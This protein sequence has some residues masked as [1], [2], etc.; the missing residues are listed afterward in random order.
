MTTCS[1]GCFAKVEPRLGEGAPVFLCDYPPPM[2]ALAKLCDDGVFPV[3]ERF[4]LYACG[5]E[6][7]NG[8]TELRDPAEQRT[9]FVDQITEKK[10]IYGGEYT[11]DE[12]FLA[13][14]PQ[15]PPCAGN[16]LGL[17]RLVMLLLGKESVAEIIPFPFETGI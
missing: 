6:L 16:A 12:A 15:M 7:C 17:D 9:R 3:A 4:E 14:L 8:F 1:S 5:V 13:A 2:A 11:L 10:K